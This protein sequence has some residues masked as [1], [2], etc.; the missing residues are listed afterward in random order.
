[1]LVGENEEKSIPKL[2]LVEHAL[3]LFPSLDNSVTI[4]AINN[5]DDTLGILEVM[6]PQRSDL[7]LS[8]NIPDSELNVLIFDG[9]DVKAYYK[10]VL[11][12]FYSDPRQYINDM[13]NRICI[14]IVG[15]VVTISPSFSLY[16]IV[17]FPAASK[18]T[19]RILISFFPHSLSNSFE[20]VRPMMSVC[21]EDM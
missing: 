9:L 10:D 4:V 20:N 6:S 12:F 13:G 19:M 2:V 18:P 16:R 8:T 3:Q 17:V 11:A 5:E 7:V 1:L 15:I 14:P 21:E